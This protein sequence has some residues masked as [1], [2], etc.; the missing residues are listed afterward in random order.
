M[1]CDAAFVRHVS[2]GANAA[3]SS[4]LFVS[5]VYCV[6][7]ELNAELGVV[8]MACEAFTYKVVMLNCDE[9]Y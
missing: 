5:T 4:R 6:C 1:T 3:V 2:N 8:D 9:C 7:V